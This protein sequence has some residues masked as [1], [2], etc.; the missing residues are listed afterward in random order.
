MMR[1]T[2]SRAVTNMNRLVTHQM[3]QAQYRE[4]GPLVEELLTQVRE[5]HCGIVSKL[6]VVILS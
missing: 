6:E 5:E 2:I 4:A 1:G 3:F